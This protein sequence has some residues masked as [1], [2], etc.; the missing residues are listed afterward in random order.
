MVSLTFDGTTT[1]VAMAK[2]LGCCFEPGKLKTYFSHPEP[3]IKQNI[4]VFLDPCHML[5]LIRNT[6]AVK[7]LWSNKEPVCWKF[8]EKLH[9]L[10]EGES[11]HLGNKLKSSHIKFTKQK[12]KGRYAAQVF[13]ASIADALEFCEKELNLSD[14]EGCNATIKFIRIINNLF[15]ILNSKNLRQFGYKKPIQESNAEEILSCLEECQLFLQ[16]IE[17]S[18]SGPDI[19]TTRH[20]TGFLGR[21]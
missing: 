5:K 2:S 7:T 12:M 18:N 3:Q 10:Q 19:V 13:S 15:D 20:K 21:S 6:L 1:N 17:C 4:Y 16:N 9:E 11:L 8:I 14:F